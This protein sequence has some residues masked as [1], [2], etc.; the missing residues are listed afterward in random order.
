M[1]KRPWRPRTYL[2]DGKEIDSKT[3]HGSLHRARKD[4]DTCDGCLKPIKAGMEYIAIL[5]FCPPI[6][7]KMCYLKDLFAGQSKDYF[8][9]LAVARKTIPKFGIK[10]TAVVCK[11]FTWADLEGKP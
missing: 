3:V 8:I 1:P 9:I 6:L 7:H 11:K 2:L 10:R 4:K 5:T